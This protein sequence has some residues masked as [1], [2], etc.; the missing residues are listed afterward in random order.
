[1]ANRTF[2][3]KRLIEIKDA[4]P[5][6][7]L[8]LDIVSILQSSGKSTRDAAIAAADSLLSLHHQKDY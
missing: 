8:G 7:T 3:V 2:G 5:A 1:M 4:E 6:K